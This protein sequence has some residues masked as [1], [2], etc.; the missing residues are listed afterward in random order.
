MDINSSYIL[1]KREELG[2][3]YKMCEYH[4]RNIIGYLKFA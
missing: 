4:I 1:N 3:D 2:D